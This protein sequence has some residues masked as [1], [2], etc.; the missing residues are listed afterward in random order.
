ML[1]DLFFLRLRH[2]SPRY[3]RYALMNIAYIKLISVKLVWNP[4][5]FSRINIKDFLLG[6]ILSNLINFA[7]GIQ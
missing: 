1:Q 5:V 7:T 4:P 2:F 6:I 3:A